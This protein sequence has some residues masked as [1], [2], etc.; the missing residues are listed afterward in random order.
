M[1]L[2]RLWQTGSNGATLCLQSRRP[3]I[4]DD[5]D[6]GNY[7]YFLFQGIIGK[8]AGKFRGKVVAITDKRVRII[9][10][11]SCSF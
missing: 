8:I 2:P 9:H 6:G 5:D 10:A 3:L 7:D 4:D 1:N 11:V